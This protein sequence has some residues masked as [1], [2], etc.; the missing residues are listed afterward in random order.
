M[1]DAST[2]SSGNGSN[3]GRTSTAVPPRGTKKGGSGRPPARGGNRPGGGGRGHQAR[4]AARRR[5]RTYALLSVGVVVVVVAVLVIVAVSSNSNGGAPRQ[6]ATASDQAALENIPL[7]TL[8]AAAS[9][10]TQLNSANGAAGGGGGTLTVGGKP[11]LLF[12]GAEFCPICAAERWPMTIALMKFG[13]FT[14]LKVTHSAVADGNAGTISYFGSTYTS[15]Y[16][17]FS[18]HELYT[19]Q[20]TATYYKA[21]ETLPK[22]DQTVWTANEGSNVSFPFIDFGG[23]EVLE[24]S[25]FNPSS[26]YYHSFSSVLGAVGSNDNT[27]GASVDASAA[28]FVKYLCGLTNGQPGSVCSAVAKVAAPVTSSNTG[29]TTPAG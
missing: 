28:V 10:V 12:I 14:N 26:I 1:T 7:S 4:Q 9:K 3:S 19:N 2:P 11:E 16:L 18:P 27:I 23:K 20:P 21:L 22:A 6:P 13:K 24:T 25:Q 15:Q 5:S 17:V 8:T 29:S